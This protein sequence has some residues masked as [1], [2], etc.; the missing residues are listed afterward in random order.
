MRSGAVSMRRALDQEHGYAMIIVILISSMLSLLALSLLEI[1]QAESDRSAQS[2]R[3]ET[4]FQAA[5]A[6]VG[7]YIAKLVDDRLY[8]AHN[9]HV[10][11]STRRPASGPDVA[12]RGVR[13]RDHHGG[14]RAPPAV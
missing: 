14:R 4:A 8:Y 1:V 9:V 7:D 11:E 10:A 2:G 6:G 3:K 12:Q 13:R 5:E